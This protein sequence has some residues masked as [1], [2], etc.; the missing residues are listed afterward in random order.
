MLT[1]TEG[2]SVPNK[3]PRLAFLGKL[4]VSLTKNLLFTL[5][6]FLKQQPPA[7][8]TGAVGVCISW[9]HLPCQPCY[10][11]GHGEEALEGGLQLILP[12]SFLPERLPSG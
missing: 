10:F 6:Y 7:P 2:L 8:H 9:E 12:Y 3:T 5:L 11:L 4:F 1:D